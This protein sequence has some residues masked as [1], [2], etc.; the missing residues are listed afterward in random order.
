MRRRSSQVSTIRFEP[1]EEDTM[2]TRTYV[3]VVKNFG[4]IG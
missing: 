1:D 2:N 3:K 4:A